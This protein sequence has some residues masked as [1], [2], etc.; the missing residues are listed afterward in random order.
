MS[1]FT[2]VLQLNAL[3]KAKKVEEILDLGQ[4]SVLDDSWDRDL[5]NE[6]YLTANNAVKLRACSVR[7]QYNAKI[8]VF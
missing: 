1:A 3:R 8:Q 6:A 2:H 5:Y 7:D 4:F